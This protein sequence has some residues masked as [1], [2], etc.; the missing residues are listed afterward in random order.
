[1]RG[2]K[3]VGVLLLP[4]VL[5][6]ALSADTYPKSSA[7][8]VRH[9]RFELELEAGER[10]I[11]ARATIDLAVMETGPRELR[12]DLVD[13]AAVE[14]GREGMKVSAVTVGGEPAQFQHAASRLTVALSETATEGDRLRVVIDYRG[15]PA[16]G[17]GAAPNKHGVWSWFSDNWPNKARNWLPTVDHPYDKATCE[18]VVTAPGDY[19]VVSNGL[20][21]EETDLDDG[22]RRTHWRQS[23]PIATWLYTLGVTRFAVQHLPAFGDKPVQTWVYAQERDAG[24]GDFAEPTHH[25]LE[26]YS[27]RIGPFSYEKLANVQSPRTRGGMEAATAIMYGDQLVTGQRTER[28]RNVVIHEIAHQWFGNAVTEADWDDVWLSE[29]FATYFTLLFIEHAYGRDE[30]VAGLESSRD[31]IFEFYS[32]NPDYRIVHD[33]LD[34]MSRVTTRNTYQKGAW[35]LH[36]LR[37]MLGDEVFWQGIR[38]YYR[39]YRDR[40]C[41][42]EDFVRVM[43]EISERELGWFFE[44]WLYRGG[45]LLADWS[46]SYDESKSE[47]VIELEQTQPEQV[48]FRMPIPVSLQFGEEPAVRR[49]TMWIDQRSNRARFAASARPTGVTLDPE[50]QV[51]MRATNKVGDE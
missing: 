51:L 40:N 33:N 27:E 38:E 30:F 34:D 46:W 24:F 10:A 44:Q 1:M 36:M 25:V 37:G 11:E 45:A 3:V 2:P 26:F 48:V 29:G 5:G 28:L 31:F 14:T 6:A 32:E 7:L 20:L 15:V 12:F 4:F 8:D 21:V 47:V 35:T 49:E 16:D 17:L 23:V 39:R 50:I 18:M 9:Y 19:Q 13:E 43:E 41:A 42:T 22:R